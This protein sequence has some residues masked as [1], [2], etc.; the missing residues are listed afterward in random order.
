MPRRSARFPRTPPQPWRTTQ[1]PTVA[2]RRTSP[3]APPVSTCWRRSKSAITTTSPILT[4]RTHQGFVAQKLYDIYPQ[5]VTIGGKDPKTNLWQVDYGTL[6]P[7]L[8]KSVQELQA[9]NDRMKA[10]SQAKD[11]AIAAATSRIWPAQGLPLRPI[12]QC[13]DVSTMSG[14][15]LPGRTALGCL[16]TRI[17]S[18]SCSI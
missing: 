12:P 10:D 16:K 17:G 2:S 18:Y 11:A 7:L 15:R 6:T 5:A 4:N 13:A 14:G 9:E 1:P 3:I 8:V